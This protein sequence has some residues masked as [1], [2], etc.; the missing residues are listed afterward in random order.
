MTT[1]I[2]SIRTAAHS[3]EQVTM[4][5]A[6]ADTV[7]VEV[8]FTSEAEM[9]SFFPTDFPKGELRFMSRRDDNVAE[10]VY[11]LGTKH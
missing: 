10:I 7:R 1:L 3:L 2:E 8:M 5:H 4:V 11:F 9:R 6:S